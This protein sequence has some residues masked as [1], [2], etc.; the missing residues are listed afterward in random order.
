MAATPTR[1]YTGQPGTTETTLVAGSASIRLIKQ[2]V[3]CNASGASSTLNLSIVPSG[4]TAGPSNRI[5]AF[6]VVPVG[7]TTVLDLNL[8]LGANDFVSAIQTVNGAMTLNISGVT[9]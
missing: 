5:I 6:M 7:Q 9:F 8:V 3:I 1:F 2:I 4:Q